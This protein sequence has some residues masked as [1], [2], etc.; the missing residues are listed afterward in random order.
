MVKEFCKAW[1][2]NKG[3]LEEYFRTHTQDNYDR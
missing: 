2:A 1:E 3:N